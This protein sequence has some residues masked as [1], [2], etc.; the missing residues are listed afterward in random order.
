MRQFCISESVESCNQR[1]IRPFLGQI[2]RNKGHL[3][4]LKRTSKFDNSSN[5]NHL[6]QKTGN[7]PTP[8]YVVNPVEI[9][10]SAGLEAAEGH[11][12]APQFVRN[13]GWG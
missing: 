8:P 2:R 3:R 4:A 11:I 1:P 12:F 6:T 13:L 5:L 7:T 9:S 10:K